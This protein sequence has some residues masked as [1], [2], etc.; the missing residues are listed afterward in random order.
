M[1]HWLLNKRHKTPISRHKQTNHDE[2]FPQLS[3][4]IGSI[5]VSWSFTEAFTQFLLKFYTIFV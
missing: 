3:M 2:N 1:P 4:Q 5:D